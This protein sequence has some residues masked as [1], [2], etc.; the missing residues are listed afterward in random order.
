[1]P[2]ALRD[3][4]GEGRLEPQLHRLLH[5]LP[6]LVAHPPPPPSPS[7]RFATTPA[8]SPKPATTS[9]HSRVAT[10]GPA[11]ARPADGAVLRLEHVPGVVALR[12]VERPLA[13]EIRVLGPQRSGGGAAE[14][15]NADQHDC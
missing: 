1:A 7:P 11:P 6:L 3:R 9:T 4:E 13:G 14:G 5:P 8:A 15:D 12:G 10:A 2:T